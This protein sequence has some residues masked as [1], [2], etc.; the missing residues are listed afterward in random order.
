MQGWSE[1]NG[2]FII[3]PVG[4]LNSLIAA[5]KNGVQNE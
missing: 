5:L 2:E 4:N 3:R 1:E